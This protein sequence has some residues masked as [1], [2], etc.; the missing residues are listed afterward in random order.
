MNYGYIVIGKFPTASA[1]WVNRQDMKHY[2][3][4]LNNTKTWTEYNSEKKSAEY[5]LHKYDGL[6]LFIQNKLKKNSFVKLTP[7]G[8]SSG[9]WETVSDPLSKN[10]IG[11]WIRAPIFS[12]S[13]VFK[14]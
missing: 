14:N 7:N 2:F 4:N 6:D 13:I 12:D 1:I 3:V 10:T 9:N 8:Y 11:F 5:R